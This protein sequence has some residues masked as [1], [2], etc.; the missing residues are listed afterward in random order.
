[1]SQT[2]RKSLVKR[3]RLFQINPLKNYAARSGTH[4][5]AEAGHREKDAQQ[6]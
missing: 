3:V 1:M 4:H 5:H 6:G 2:I